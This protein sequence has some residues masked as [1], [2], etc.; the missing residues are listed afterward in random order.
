MKTLTGCRKEIISSVALVFFFVV[1]NLASAETKLFIEEYTY[2]A[3]EADSKLSS[4]VI[5][6]E[7]VKRLLL[8]KLGT[9]L[10]SETEV[11]NFQLTKDQI[12][13]L[14]AGIVRAE[15][16]DEKWDGRTY[17]LKA[18][19]E[20]DPQD[21]TISINKLRQ[22][23]QQVKELE[24]TRK[25]ASEALREL[26]RLK[27]ELEI[28]K[29][30]KRH[31]SQYNE[32]VNSLNATDW[33]EKGVSLGS[34]NR[35]REAI[36]AATKAIQ[37]NPKFVQAYS[38]RGFT[39]GL[40]GDYREAIKDFDIVVEMN[41]AD[42]NAYSGRGFTYG[43]LGDY[44]QAV[45]DLDRAIELDPRFAEAY[46]HRGVVYG[47][48]GDHQKAIR[49]LDKAIALNPKYAEAYFNRGVAYANLG[50]AE[51]AVEDSKI[52]ARLGNK[53]AQDFLKSAGIR[54]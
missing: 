16:I 23:R 44:R 47:K 27:K 9:Y 1:A 2:Q 10:E 21:V 31:P 52:A 51:K 32:A 20:A 35:W 26:E 36:Q 25:K 19:M 50:D 54:W 14:T 48:L 34:A 46:S 43:L 7:Q 49:D 45:I 5:A 3:S 33:F 13:I 40:L 12:V 30:D 18:K 38:Y 41:P 42:A 17:Y 4:R 8:E 24:E 37:L 53:R 22:D 6:L 28:A 29:A 11:K 39:Y 15:I